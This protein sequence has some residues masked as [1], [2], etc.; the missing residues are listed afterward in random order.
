MIEKAEITEDGIITRTL[1]PDPDLENQKINFESKIIYISGS[2]G[3]CGQ[4]T[5]NGVNLRF[6]INYNP[7]IQ[8]G[9]A[10]NFFANIYLCND[11]IEI[12]NDDTLV[13]D[14]LCGTLDQFYYLS[15]WLDIRDNIIE[16]KIQPKVFYKLTD[17]GVKI[18]QT[19]CGKL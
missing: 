12:I 5:V 2:P 8:G 11:K 10:D 15:D 7:I 3:G 4:W 6:R 16:E 14:G 18:D 19:C 1:L 13:I 9:C 17:K